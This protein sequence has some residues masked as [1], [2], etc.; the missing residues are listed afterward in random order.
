MVSEIL[1]RNR[2]KCRKQNGFLIAQPIHAGSAETF[3]DRVQK[4][5]IAVIDF[6]KQLTDHNGRQDNRNKED[7]AEDFF[8]REAACKNDGDYSARNDFKHNRYNCQY[9]RV[10]N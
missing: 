9:K 4:A 6:Q 10:Y 2:E 1:I 3:D 8:S 7:R 5:I